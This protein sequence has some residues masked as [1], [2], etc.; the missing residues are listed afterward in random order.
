MDPQGRLARRLVLAAAVALLTA[1]SFLVFPGHTYLQQDSQIYV[2]IL[3]HL[4]DPS[5]L[6]ADPVATRHH[7]TFTLYDELIL[8]LR[9][10]TG[11]ELEP[12]LA[13]DHLAARAAGIFGVYLIG[14]ALGLSRPLALGVAAIYAL[15]ANVPGPEVLTIEYEPKP[16]AS[17]VP[18]VLLAAGLIARRWYW[19]GGVAGAIAFLYHPP[20]V[21][22]FWLVYFVMELWPARPEE[23][24][25]R[26]YGIVPLA[27]A[28]VVLLIASRFQAGGPEAQAFFGT[29]DPELERL[30]KLR[31]PYAWV[32]LWPA[33]RLG[34]YLV[35]W[36]IGLA[37]CFRLWKAMPP[38]LRFFAVGLPLAGMLSLPATYVLLDRWKWVVMPKAQPARA[39]LFVTVMA[40]ILPAAACFRAA[41][42]RRLGEA[43]LWGALA[44]LPPLAP[45][46]FT[47]LPPTFSDPI[48]VRRLILLA[49]LG[50]LAAAAARSLAFKSRLA[51]ALWSAAIIAPFF[52]IPSFGRVVNY[53]QMETAE[54]LELARWA[55]EGTP[56]DAVFLFADI[57]RSQEPGIFRAK[58]LRAVYVDWKGG[59]QVNMV[60]AFGQEW[61]KRWQETMAAPFDPARLGHFARLGICYVVLQPAN[62]LRGKAPVFENARFLAYRLEPGEN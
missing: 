61:W 46:V 38:G 32:S 62:R 17:A 48:A 54:L 58:A 34:H 27:A 22:P 56:K 36:A 6:A 2:A 21:Y 51:W 9:R 26:I 3:E 5:V 20:T 41:M 7:V 33:A 15:G 1:S 11:W 47:F 55:R 12:L 60:K 35:L 59:G 4:W 52:L 8:G 45:N 53:R 14:T 37:A 43:L 19:A 24:K 44:F 23:M 31:A 49:G 50:A 29:I 10:L 57:G 30:Q 13:A 28:I 18:L 40:V 42:K 25:R 39:V 16:R